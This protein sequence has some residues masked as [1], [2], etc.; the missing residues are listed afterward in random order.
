MTGAGGGLH[1]VD[2]GLPSVLTELRDD[3]LADRVAVVTGTD[4]PPLS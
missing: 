2:L 4:L 1:V 3:R